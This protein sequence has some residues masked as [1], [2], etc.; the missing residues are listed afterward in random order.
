MKLYYTALLPLMI[1]FTGTAQVVD[2]FE[3]GTIALNEEEAYRIKTDIPVVTHKGKDIY[4]PNDLRGIDLNDPKSKWSFHR[5]V[6]T[7]NIALFWAD[8][9]GDDITKAPDLEGQNMKVDLANLLAKLE[10]FY[11]CL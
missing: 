2:P 6:E 9:F 11:N 10:Q 5:M 8:G 1:T 4:I 7:P 3:P